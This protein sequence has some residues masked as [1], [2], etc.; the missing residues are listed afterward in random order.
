MAQRPLELGGRGSAPAASKVKDPAHTADDG[1]GAGSEPP[2][3]A[4]RD[5]LSQDKQGGADLPSAVR[6]AD[7][8]MY[9]RKGSG[10]QGRSNLSLVPAN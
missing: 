10:R 3:A 8:A 9:E 1:D 6:A 7:E 2:L 4:L 5:A